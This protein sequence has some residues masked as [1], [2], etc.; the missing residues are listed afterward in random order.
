MPEERSKQ[1][2]VSPETERI[3]RGRHR[4]GEEQGGEEEGRRERIFPTEGR[5]SRN[6]APHSVCTSRSGLVAGGLHGCMELG[7]ER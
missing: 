4:E 6:S 5:V 3:S 1:G 2:A 7:L